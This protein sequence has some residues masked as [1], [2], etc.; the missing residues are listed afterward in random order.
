MEFFSGELIFISSFVLV[1]LKAMQQQNVIHGNWMMV[2]FVSM[3]LACTEVAIVLFVV[4][5]GWSAIPWMGTGAGLGA[6][7]AMWLHRRIFK[8]EEQ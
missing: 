8:R 4:E 5:N 6:V 1:F 7:F 3:G 2:P